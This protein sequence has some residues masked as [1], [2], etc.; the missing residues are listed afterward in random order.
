MD[1]IINA[2]AAVR[3]QQTQFVLIN[4][5][6]AGAAQMIVL[7][8]LA[9]YGP[10]ADMAHTAMPDL[11]DWLYDYARIAVQV[12]LVIG[13]FLAARS[14]APTAQPDVQ[15]PL[16]L[17]W[18]RYLKLAPPFIAAMLLAVLASSWASVWMSDPSISPPP[19]FSQMAAHV[20]LLHGVLGMES[21]S[22]GAWYV[23]I[24]FQ[25][26]ALLTLLLWL[27]GRVSPG[28]AP[29]WLMPLLVLGGVFASLCYFNLD[30]GWDVWAPYFFGAYGLGALAWW[31]S[32]P[33]RNPGS[34]R[35]SW[36][37][38]PAVIALSIDFRS[39]IAVAA[40]TACVLVLC[41][42]SRLGMPASGPAAL[43]NR[44]GTI[45]YS[46]FLVHFPVCLMVNAAFNRF[47]TP[48]PE[49]ALA[50]MA[51]A[52][53]AS[54]TVGALFHRWVEAPLGRLLSTPLRPMA[55]RAAR[56]LR[57]VPVVPAQTFVVWRR[58]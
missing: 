13:G 2:P 15:H 21:L 36:L 19:T 48:E 44:L 12:F 42:R 4:M 5:L 58:S 30:A 52:W 38:A 6:K 29:Q 24:D 9:F 49:L 28:R 54:L 10:M 25:L 14:L 23:A 37:L 35:W 43:L 17:I 31:V 3:T 53:C 1:A 39:R 34:L 47:V 20:F 26:Y 51:L 55:P 22:A 32:D 16:Q 40:I 7:H 8:H 27:V 56:L 41:G 46:I 50:G 11:I 18:R 57:F 33:E 45:S